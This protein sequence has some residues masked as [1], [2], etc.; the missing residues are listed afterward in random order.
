MNP[1]AAVLTPRQ[2]SFYDNFNS[3]IHSNKPLV[4]MEMC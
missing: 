4:E 3:A 2:K 1:T